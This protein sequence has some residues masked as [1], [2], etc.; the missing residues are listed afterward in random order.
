MREIKFRAWDKEFN[1]MYVWWKIQKTNP[2]IDYFQ[3]EKLTIMS[4]TGLKDKNGIDIYEGDIVKYE[5]NYCSKE[6]T[7][8]RIAK[9]IFTID[10][11]TP[12]FILDS[13]KGLMNMSNHLNG[14]EVIGNI[15]ENPE[16]LKGER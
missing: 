2:T 6:Q 10:D 16:L 13:D 3:I 5:G 14:L 7:G 11:D 12:C 8:M 4:F 15:Y 9:V 1:K